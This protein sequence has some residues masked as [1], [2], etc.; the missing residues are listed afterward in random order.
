M[1]KISFV[2][3]VTFKS[4]K[5]FLSNKISHYIMAIKIT[6]GTADN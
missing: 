4:Y 1:A 5:S 3:E 2:V 6:Q